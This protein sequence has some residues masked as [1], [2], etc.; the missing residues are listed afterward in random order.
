MKKAKEYTLKNFII[1]TSEH[2][3]AEGGGMFTILYFQA[4]RI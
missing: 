4:T 1:N 2:P 3:A